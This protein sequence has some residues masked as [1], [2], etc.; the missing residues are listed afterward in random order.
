MMRGLT[1]EEETAMREVVVCIDQNL[2]GRR[3]GDDV[4]FS[5]RER[6]AIHSI[7]CGIPLGMC[8]DRDPDHTH[9]LPTAS[10]RAALA[11]MNALRTG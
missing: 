8:Q 11:C 6:G 4:V 2:P 5:L 7:P 1:V 3:I 9:L 10:G